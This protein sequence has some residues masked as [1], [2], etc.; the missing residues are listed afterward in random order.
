MRT[1]EES[2]V[3]EEYRIHERRNMDK[4]ILILD[5]PK[6]CYD[7]NC[8]KRDNGN[9]C[10]IADRSVLQCKIYKFIPEWCPLKPLPEKKTVRPEDSTGAVAVKYGWNNC[11]DEILKEER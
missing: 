2:E 7:C 5:M 8:S 9:F 4:A 6:S 10:S 1:A 11:I 3:P